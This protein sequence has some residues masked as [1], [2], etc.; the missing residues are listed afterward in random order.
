MMECPQCNN[1]IRIAFS[2][3]VISIECKNCL[4]VSVGVITKY[5]V[6]DIYYK[7]ISMMIRGGHKK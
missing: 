2:S 1:K 7:F 6:E 5:S 3:R 4:S